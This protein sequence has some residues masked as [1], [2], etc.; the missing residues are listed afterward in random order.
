MI[1]KQV[2]AAP[3][4]T[5]G[6]VG[7]QTV[8]VPQR[9]RLARAQAWLE[10]AHNPRPAPSATARASITDPDAPLMLS[11]KGGYLQGYNIHIASG[12]NQLLLAIEV[13]DNPNDIMALVPLVRTAQRNC[14]T[15]QVGGQV[16][17]WVADVGYASTA[18]FDTLADIPPLV[19]VTKNAAYRRRAALVEPG[20]AQLFSDRAATSTTAGAPAWLPRSS[21]NQAQTAHICDLQA[22]S[23]YA[24]AGPS[25]LTTAGPCPARTTT[26]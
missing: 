26:I 12:H 11:K 18:N 1:G 25:R 3:R 24:E 23:H 7:G 21:S 2:G 22:T 15:A 9:A 19:A 5:T 10:Q 16:Q 20:F 6:A 14:D 13:H 17:A 4:A 8:V